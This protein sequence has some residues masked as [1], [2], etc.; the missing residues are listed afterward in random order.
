M[1]QNDPL[2]GN[3]ARIN[4]EGH[5][6][7]RAISVPS[8][9]HTNHNERECYTMDLD[10]VVVDGDGYFLVSLQNTNDDDLI[11]TSIT[12]W[13]ATSKDDCNVEVTLNGTL[14]SAGTTAVTPVNCSGK[15]NNATGTFYKNDG[16]GN[17]TVTTTGDIVSRRKFS[18]TPYKW[19]KKSGWILTKNDVMNIVVTKDNTFRG[20]ISFFYH[21]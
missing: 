4:K 15:G 3:A 21:Y 20:Y 12:L 8:Q 16:A 18:S 13:T 5:A 19:E 9:Q 1:I 10:N 7:T 14:A 17:M 11:V 6:L 2:T